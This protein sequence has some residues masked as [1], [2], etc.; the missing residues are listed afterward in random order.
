MTF[1]RETFIIYRRQIRMNLRNPAWVIIGMLQPILY[2]ALFGPLLEP[3]VDQFGATNAYTFFVPGLLVQLGIFGAMFAGFSLIGEWRDGVVEAERVTPASRTALLMGRMLRDITQL[4][5]Q[6]VILIGLGYVF[7]MRASLGG[8]LLGLLLTILIGAAC[9][10]SSNAVALTT[11][12]EDV[13]APLLNMVMMPV[14]LLSGIL[15]PMT[16]GPEWLQTVSDVIPVKHIVS[17]VRDT[18]AGDIM[19][20]TV[21]WGTGWTLLLFALAVWWGTAVFRR[22]NS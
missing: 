4:A 5:V 19:T 6:A 10:A 2:L 13:M 17:A 1:L 21:A 20:S 12:S 22:E 11:K 7:G 8:L 3:L 18:F 14:L 15:L 9:A 16:I